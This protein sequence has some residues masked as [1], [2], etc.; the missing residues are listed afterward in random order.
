M[1]LVLSLLGVL[2]IGAWLFTM[3]NGS[4]WSDFDL[5]GKFFIIFLVFC[6]LASCLGCAAGVLLMA[7]NRDN[8]KSDSSRWE[9]LSDDEK[10]WY[11]DNYGDGQYDA[12]QDAIS[13]Y[14]N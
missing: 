13:D 3:L 7:E 10:E 4:K 1:I 14:A 2:L 12:I 9:S 8:S 5:E 11:N 6:L